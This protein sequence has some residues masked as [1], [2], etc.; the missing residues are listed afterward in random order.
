MSGAI[1]N[2]IIQIVGG[3]IG[4]NAVGGL[5][6][7]IVLSPLLKTISVP[8]AEVLVELSCRA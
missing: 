8:W 4:G 5:F 2:L 6:K 7:N 3:A 1:F